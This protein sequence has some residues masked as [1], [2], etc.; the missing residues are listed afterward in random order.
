[1][2]WGE[3]SCSTVESKKEML[4]VRETFIE[5]CYM[6]TCLNISLRELAQ[7]CILAKKYQF[8]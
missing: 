7:S 4:S 2:I 3:E 1:M 8:S 5:I 6:N